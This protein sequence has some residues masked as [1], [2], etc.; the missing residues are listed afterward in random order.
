M[1]ITP[2]TTRPITPHDTNLLKILDEYVPTFPE[3]GIMAITSKIVSITEGRTVRADK[4]DLAQ[5]VAQES[6]RYLDPKASKYGIALTIKDSILIPNAGIDHSNS[7]DWLTL[8]PRDAQKTANMVRQYLKKR[9]NLKHCGVIITDSKTSPLR[10]GTTGVCLAHSGFLALNDYRGKKDVFN[11]PL[12][13][14]QA[15]IADGLASAAVLVMGEGAE[16]TPLA[17][18]ADASNVSFQ[19]RNPT[20][21]E[22]ADLTI[23]PK[24]DLYGPLLESAPWHK[25]KK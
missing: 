7:G 6:D 3:K 1:T 24:G 20:K 21:K 19:D 9:F 13:V 5:L 17:L 25:G 8:W 14:T 22:L 11:Q 4:A 15:N 18:I 16:Q 12:L 2:I 23:D 10:W